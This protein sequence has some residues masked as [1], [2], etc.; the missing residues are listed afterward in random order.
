ML[1]RMRKQGKT[2][3]E[4]AKILKRTSSSVSSKL[5]ALGIVMQESTTWPKKKLQ[6]LKK[7]YPTT[8]NAEL[9][10]MFGCTHRAVAAQAFKLRLK[11]DREWWFSRVLAS[12]GL[13]QKG[14]KSWNKGKKY[15]H[16]L[17]KEKLKNIR[18]NQFK[19][20]STPANTQPVG[21]ITLRNALGNK[22]NGNNSYFYI[23]VAEGKWM[24]LHRYVWMK[25]GRK[26]LKDHLI[27]FKD[28]N[29]A[30][31]KL[32]NLEQITRK[33]GMLRN[34]SSINLK[35]T[36]VAY[37]IATK[38]HPELIPIIKLDKNLI[39]AK[40]QVLILK[41]ELSKQNV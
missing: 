13:F 28:G 17:S 29:I 35:D 12:K 31:C 2:P 36:Y 21:T 19:K 41:R 32:S 27:W 34:S 37:T 26:L 16:T 14:Q 20:G 5:S 11:K 24:L 25:A 7:L 22:K 40:R 23:K 38:N 33:E 8:T 30:N 39:E 1:E 6:K 3:A 4:I 10:V 15:Q 9:G 18:A